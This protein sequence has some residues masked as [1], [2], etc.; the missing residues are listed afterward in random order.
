MGFTHYWYINRNGN[1]EQWTEGILAASRILQ[2]VISEKTVPLANA[3]GEE[4]TQ[5]EFGDDGLYFNGV[6]DD[7]HESM[8]LPSVVAQV[9]APDYRK[10]ENP[11]FNFCKTARKPYDVVVTAVLAT[12]RAYAPDCITVASDGGEYDW[13]EGVNL[14]RR[15]LGDF[16]I[17]CPLEKD[18]ED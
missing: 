10:D 17:V 16:D 7:A 8:V 13:Q 4:G 9:E 14:A 12:L 3:Y 2:A 15:V 6:E 18:E 5:P 1:Q 11:V